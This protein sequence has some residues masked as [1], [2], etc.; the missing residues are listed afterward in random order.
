MRVER[1]KFDPRFVGVNACDTLAKSSLSRNATRF[2]AYPRHR[3]DPY[4]HLLSSLFLLS[5][6]RSW[7]KRI[8][9]AIRLGD[10]TP[11]TSRRP[12]SVSYL[13]FS[14]LESTNPVDFGV[15]GL[16]EKSHAAYVDTF[17][18]LLPWLRLCPLHTRG[19]TAFAYLLHAPL[20]LMHRTESRLDL[21]LFFFALSRPRA[22]GPRWLQRSS[23]LQNIKLNKNNVCRYAD[24][25]SAL[26]RIFTFSS[27]LRFAACST[28][29][30]FTC[31]ECSVAFLMWV[32][33]CNVMSPPIFEMNAPSRPART[34]NKALL[35]SRWSF[36]GDSR[37]L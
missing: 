18:L 34:R 26:P 30:A 31:N 12:I 33:G 17:I 7:R 1:G 36:V 8:D 10:S 6:A 4:P 11:E 9:L 32:R 20:G 22:R 27:S 29:S 25:I 23:R 13:K 37:S 21:F 14:W 3:E 35:L 28:S 2:F 5:A 19:K 15:R 24:G 16:K